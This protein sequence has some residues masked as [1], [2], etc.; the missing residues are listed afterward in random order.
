MYLGSTK[1][2]LMEEGYFWINGGSRE[3]WYVGDDLFA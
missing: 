1:G 2:S 3:E